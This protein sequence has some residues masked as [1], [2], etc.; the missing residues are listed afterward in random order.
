[1][2][3][4]IDV[5]C[6]SKHP[7]ISNWELQNLLTRKS[8]LYDNYG[9]F[10]VRITNAVRYTRKSAMVLY[11]GSSFSSS[12]RIH[13]I[14]SIIFSTNIQKPSNLRNLLT[15]REYAVNVAFEENLLWLKYW[16][17]RPA[18]FCHF[19]FIERNALL[20][21]LSPIIFETLKMLRKS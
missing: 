21:P 5:H 14:L 17:P 9:T 12:K 18:A 15:C 13:C 10:L 19:K 11:L 20:L 2:D 4:F 3:G 1:M 8:P 7:F 16:K 6:Q